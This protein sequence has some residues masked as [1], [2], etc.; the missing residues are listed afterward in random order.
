LDILKVKHWQL[1]LS[2]F[3]ILIPFDVVLTY[4]AYVWP[5]LWWIDSLASMLYFAYPV[6]VWKRLSQLLSGEAL[7][8]RANS[9]K[10]SSAVIASVILMVCAPLIAAHFPQSPLHIAVSAI[11][12]ISLSFICAVPGK[13]LKSIELKRNAGIWEYVPEA[14]QFFIWP[15]GVLWLQPRINRVL[16]RKIIIKE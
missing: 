1:L 6:L 11:L 2:F 14:F 5:A 4:A 15:L 13:Q 10:V 16:E 12:L 3:A 7:F 9:K 8:E